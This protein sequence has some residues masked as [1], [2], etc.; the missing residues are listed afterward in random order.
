M[1]TRLDIP[2]WRLTVLNVLAHIYIK[3]KLTSPHSDL[4][5]FTDSDA[6]GNTISEDAPTL[7]EV[8]SAVRPFK[9]F[10][11]LNCAEKPVSEA[12]A[13]LSGQQ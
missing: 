12:L 3:Q 2:S 13:S 11:L 5:D 7:T 9:W 1:Y 6:A 10:F 4:D 8:I